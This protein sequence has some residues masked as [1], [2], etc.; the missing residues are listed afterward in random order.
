MPERIQIITVSASGDTDR[1]VHM[2]KKWCHNSKDPL[3]QSLSPSV[4]K[5]INLD[6]ATNLVG[7]NNTGAKIILVPIGFSQSEVVHY[8]SE[9]LKNNLE[10]IIRPPRTGLNMELDTPPSSSLLEACRVINVQNTIPAIRK[11]L[12]RLTLGEEVRIS[13]LQ[14]Q[15]QLLSYFRLRYRVWKDMGYLKKEYDCSNS[16]LEVDYTDESA[17]PIGAFNRDNILIGC[18]RLVFARKADITDSLDYDFM[19][20]SMIGEMNDC[21]LTRSYQR[22]FAITHPFD[23]LE[24]FSRFQRYYRLLVRRKLH[25]AEISR[26]IVEPERRKQGLGEILVDTLVSIA[27][28]QRVNALFLACHEH[29]KVFYQR[30]GFHSLPGLWADHFLAVKKPSIAMACNLSNQKLPVIH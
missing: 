12:L 17:I 14:T 9:T 30:C 15:E 13:Y 19:I 5:E 23:V 25:K 21:C 6:R 18:A 26:V 29:H 16:C 27:R 22:P 3:V 1:V 4:S 20:R 24:G 7:Q 8:L 10:V 28:Q 2:I 11:S